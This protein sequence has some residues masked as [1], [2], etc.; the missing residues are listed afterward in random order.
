MSDYK[1][2][3]LNLG[4]G[5]DIPE[6]DTLIDMLSPEE[7]FTLGQE[8]TNTMKQIIENY[9]QLQKKYSKLQESYWKEMAGEDL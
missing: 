2:K 6:I 4:K 9:H 8:I 5:L 3:L 1:N 7:F